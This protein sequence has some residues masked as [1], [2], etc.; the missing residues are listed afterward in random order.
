M[1]H[2]LRTPLNSIIGFAQILSQDTSFKPEQQQRLSII[3]R[4]GEHLL[5]LINDI[6]EMSK[7]EAGQ[8]TLNEKDFDLHS[9]LQNM[10]EMFCLK[11]QNKG[12]K[13]VL[14]LDSH[15]PQ[16]IS[17]DEAKLRQVLIN[18]IGN[19]VKF[20]EKGKITL[21]ANLG[22]DEQNIQHTLNLEVED[23]GPGI[24]PEELD[25]LFVP[26]EQTTAGRKVR[27]G[28][29][30][31]LSITHKFIE[32]MGGNITARSTV[33]V[34]T[35]FQCVI[36]IHLASSQDFPV[37]LAKG[38]VI[39]LASGQPS[40]RILV[41]DDEPDNRLLLL[42]LLTSVGLSVQQASNGRD[43]IG[44]WQVW[45]P[46]LIWMDLRMPE[47][48]GYEATRWIREAE[49]RAAGGAGGAEGVEEE[50]GGEGETRGHGDG[51]DGGVE[52][53]LAS[54]QDR[55]DPNQPK[56]KIQNPKSKIQN[57]KPPT[58]IALTASVF[59]GKRNLTLASGFDDYVVKPFQEEV[60]WQK[61]RQY[62]GI[63]FIY[64]PLVEANAK[65]LQ[66]DDGSR[67]SELSR[68][69][70]RPQGYAPRVAS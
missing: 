43:A 7:I 29:G 34:G 68:F 8:I 54:V 16:Y 52:A 26:F 32:L 6:L 21:S 66:K 27:Q 33:G 17:T 18:L 4:S 41:V 22:K 38:R 50:S 70:S 5:S 49:V 59:K 63:E 23:T 67:A 13:F 46:Q 25:K 37:K 12:L 64:Q 14:E 55:I 58:I 45:R 24:A 35:C 53:G 69:I 28:T 60:I 36:P 48:D 31:G 44:I 30:L 1:S 56:S 15:L 40:Y 61:L 42:D 20:T 57:L 9:L 62:L 2:E 51:E 47:M 39:G 19:A 3:N 10:Q 11:V 65:G